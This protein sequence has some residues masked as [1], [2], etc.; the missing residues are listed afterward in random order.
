MGVG[1]GQ[2]H[3]THQRERTSLPIDITVTSKNINIRLGKL[4]LQVSTH[5]A[6]EKL[7]VKMGQFIKFTFLFLFHLDLFLTVCLFCVYNE[8]SE[9]EYRTMS[10]NYC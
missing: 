6:R 1:A 9:S 10:K 3:L 5:S 4:F 7:Q 2:G 8:L